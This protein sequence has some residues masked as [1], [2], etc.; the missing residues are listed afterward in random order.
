M[1][2]N[3]GYQGIQ[4]VRGQKSSAKTRSIFTDLREQISQLWNKEGFSSVDQYFLMREMVDPS[5]SRYVQVACAS[6]IKTRNE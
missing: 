6:T 5:T 1:G 4:Y 3:R 2:G